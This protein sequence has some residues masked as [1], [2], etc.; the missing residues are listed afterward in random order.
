MVTT[1][2][3]GR[4]EAALLLRPDESAFAEPVPGEAWASWDECDGWS[5]LVRDDAVTSDV[6]KGLG[7]LPDPGDVSAWA[8]TLLAHP[9][10]T[11]SREDH[12]F[13]DHSVADPEFEVQLAL[14]QADGTLAERHAGTPQGSP[15]S[16]VLANLFM[17]YASGTWIA[18][19][20][21]GVVFERFADDIVVHCKTRR[22]AG[23]VAAAIAGRLGELPR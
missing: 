11:P 3:D 9:E 1:A 13:R 7:V 18:R 15:L 22:Q 21:P 5:L 17:H 19:E 10:V 14:Q 16:P 20:C 2:D 8:V 4:R 23:Q 6:Y 12:P